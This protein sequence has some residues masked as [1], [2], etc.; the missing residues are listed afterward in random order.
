MKLVRASMSVA[1]LLLAIQ[2]GAVACPSCYGAADSPMTAGMDAA[3]LV[4]LGI[5]GF[6]LSLI[7]GTFFYLWRR[8]RRRLSDLSRQAYVD[9]CGVL[10]SKNE[11]GVVEWNIF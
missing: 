8:A 7:G 11:K 9:E 2:A 10:K 6:V 5:T 4:M 1:L 3:I